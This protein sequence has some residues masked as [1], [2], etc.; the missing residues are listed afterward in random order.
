KEDAEE[1]VQEVFLR[2]W[3]DR[4]NLNPELS[5]KSFL[6]TIAYNST[7]N[8]LRKRAFED[9]YRNMIGLST[10]SSDLATEKE[11]NYRETLGLVEKAIDLLPPKR[12]QV[13]QMSRFEG[14]TYQEIADQLSV[15]VKTVNDHM[16]EALKFLRKNLK[17][18]GILV[19][20]LFIKM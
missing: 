6:F 13:F 19:W 4:E 12:K 5:L 16:N 1:I 3:R 17:E 18:Y 8:A 14:L 20:Y 11:I 9:Q 2:I 15:S 10:I 7:V